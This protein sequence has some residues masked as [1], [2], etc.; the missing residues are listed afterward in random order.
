[1]NSLPLTK[2]LRSISIL[3]HNVERLYK[4]KCTALSSPHSNSKIIT[5]N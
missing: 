3:L 5:T 4:A 2:L 1:M